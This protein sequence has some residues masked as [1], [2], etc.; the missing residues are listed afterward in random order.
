MT[1]NV[2]RPNTA[3]RKLSSIDFQT[4]GSH[5]A[6]VSKNQGGGANGHNYALIMKSNFS[7]EFIQKASMI[8]VTLEITEFLQK[9]FYVYGSDAE[10]LAR[11]LGFT[12]AMQDDIAENEAEGNDTTD[13]AEGPD[14]E[15][16]YETEYE[17]YIQ[18]KVQ[19]FQVMKSL[20]EADSFEVALSTVQEDDY[21]KVLQDQSTLEKVLDTVQ[22]SKAKTKKKAKPSTTRDYSADSSF[23]VVSKSKEDI[24]MKEEL[25]KSLSE[26]KVLL[27]KALEQIEVFKAKEKEAIQKARFAELT[28]VVKNEDQAKVL[29]KALN[30]IEDGAEYTAAVQVLK[31][32]TEVAAKSELF[33]EAGVNVEEDTP[34]VKESAVAKAVKAQI[35]KS[36]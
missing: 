35:S 4:E 7:P 23:A 15:D 30:L 3:K 18:S 12:T 28:S 19:S 34:V 5:I 31:Q 6:L 32:V 2:N 14:Y 36:K 10:I 11:T 25:E 17:K 20:F 21:L 29:F 27:E 1:T 16:A 33:K 24:K 13:S 22:K 9:F 26:Q 8:T